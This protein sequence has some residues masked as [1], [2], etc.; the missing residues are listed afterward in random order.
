MGRAPVLYLVD[1]PVLRSFAIPCV[2]IHHIYLS[3]D[4]DVEKLLLSFV[5]VRSLSTTIRIQIFTTEVL[6]DERLAADLDGSDSFVYCTKDICPF[7]IDVK[8][9]R[10]PGECDQKI[11]PRSKRG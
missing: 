6:L 9:R 2:W 10:L 7:K 8:S 11:S 3:Y 4:W 1:L 5:S